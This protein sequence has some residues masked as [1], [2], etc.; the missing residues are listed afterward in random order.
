MQRP[1]TFDPGF[2][3]AEMELTFSADVRIRY[4]LDTEAAIAVVE[5]QHGVIPLEAAAAI[6][7]LCHAVDLN[8]HQIVVDGWEQGTPVV[9]LLE[10]LRAQLPDEQAR[11]LHHGATTQDIVDTAT[12]LQC[13]DAIG[14][15]AASV[16]ATETVLVGVVAEHRATPISGRTFLQP[17][18]GT[19]FGLVAAG[20]CH[21]L[22][23]A[24]L[25]LVD[26]QDSLPVQFGGPVGDLQSLGGNA[27]QIL[28]G[29][30]SG[31]GLRA[32]SIPWHGD[33]STIRSLASAVSNL[34]SGI[35]KVAEDLVLLAQHGE[36]HMR[37]GVSSSM[38]HKQNPFDAV[39]ALAAARGAIASATAITA[40]PPHELQRA[41]GAWHAE[42][43]AVPMLFHCVGGA[44]AA[45]RHAVDSIEVDAATM[46]VNLASAGLDTPDR[47]SAMVL[48]DRWQ[49]DLE[50]PR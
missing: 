48:L 34:A 35:A 38:P 14:H 9:P 10:K 3:T 32:P 50:E 37:I 44:A 45:L 46:M 30:A 33:R 49:D 26:A 19:T 17:A 5:G 7:D 27:G 43:W 36:V 20:W 13:R 24:R 31:L 2:S 21:I 12:M 1:P 15:V 11:W 42:S 25:H 8:A 40:A 39:H 22:R 18:L 6:S 4:M 29:L 41:A 28:D 47:A 23:G 16:E